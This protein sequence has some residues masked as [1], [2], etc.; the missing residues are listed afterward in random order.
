MIS[1]LVFKHVILNIKAVTHSCYFMIILPWSA[2]TVSS[3][4]EA[5]IEFCSSSIYITWLFYFV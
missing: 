1:E 4:A 5:D 2:L 3:A